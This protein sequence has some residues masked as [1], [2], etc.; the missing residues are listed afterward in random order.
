MS[1]AWSQPVKG[2]EKLVLLALADHADDEGRCW[3]GMEGIARKCGLSRRA[4]ISS[5][6]ALVERGLVGRE[7]RMDEDSGA[8]RSNVY[9]L[10][11]MPCENSAPPRAESAHTPVQ[12]LH[13]PREAGFTPPRAESAHR[14]IN[15]NHQGKQS[16]ARQ[17]LNGNLFN[18]AGFDRFWTAYPKKRSKGQA[19]KAW[20]VLRPDAD[21]ERR[22]L[23]AVESAKST[24]DWRKDAGQ[25]IPHPATWLRAEG[26]EDAHEPPPGAHRD[27]VELRDI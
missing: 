27:R 15:M 5:V 14:T 18:A 16:I 8:R 1:W 7:Q 12:D 20:H 21:L 13:G 26:W 25:F 9:T 24:A 6:K 23:R 11:V 2:S 10:A 22:I 3:P 4:A 19:R 17:H